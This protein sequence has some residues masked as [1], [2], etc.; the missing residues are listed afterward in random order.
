MI[1]PRSFLAQ[2]HADVRAMVFGGPAGDGNVQEGDLVQWKG[3]SGV[4]L[5]SRAMTAAR[6]VSSAAARLT[7]QEMASLRRKR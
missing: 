3:V 6:Q 7:V 5:H 2:D 1:G 4:K